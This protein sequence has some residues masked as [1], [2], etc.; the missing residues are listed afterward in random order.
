MT[1]HLPE[2]LESSI[3]VGLHRCHYASLDDPMA[4]AAALL[5]GSLS[6]SGPGDFARGFR[7]R[8]RSGTPA[9]LGARPG[10]VGR[11]PDDGVRSRPVDGAEM[12]DHYIDGTPKRHPT[13]RSGYPP[14]RSTGLPS[15]I[16]M[17]SPT[18]LATKVVVRASRAAQ[19]T[20][21]GACSMSLPVEEPIHGD[22]S[23]TNIQVFTGARHPRVACDPTWLSATARSALRVRKH[24]PVSQSRRGG[25][26]KPMPGPRYQGPRWG[27]QASRGTL[28][29]SLR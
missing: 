5:R 4:V 14:T 26:R 3:L 28:R 19:A 22:D 13:P 23:P 12:H 21:S 17:I 8:N 1:I 18:N 6:K 9:H 10:T 24:L 7:G 16:K 29:S 2:N 25:N 11:L 27:D 15:P 20:V